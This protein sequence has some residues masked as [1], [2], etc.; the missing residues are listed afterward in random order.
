MAQHMFD[1]MTNRVPD[2]VPALEHWT[3]AA[4]H[5]CGDL[6]LFERT[7]SGA[8]H[9]FLGDF[10]GHGLSAAIGAIPT[11]DIFFAMTRKG[12]TLAE[13]VLEI[14][15]KLYRLLPMGQFCA[16]IAVALN[17]T[18]HAM[19]VWSGGAPPVL[20]LDSQRHIVG[21]VEANN[22]PLGAV[23]EERFNALPRQVELHGA[24]H[25]LLC[26]DGLVEARDAAGAL[27]GDHDFGRLLWH[28]DHAEGSILDALR[29][30]VIDFLSGMEPHDDISIMT[31]DLAAAS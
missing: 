15:R 22:F 19:E 21:Q 26:S 10:T 3:L 20:L 11:A 27:F 9:V 6:M 5:F 29:K 23:K 7:P 31:L 13:I 12:C 8:L 1:S 16:A 30:G 17:P 24:S 2:D 4:G 25:I 14:N 28:P 18:R